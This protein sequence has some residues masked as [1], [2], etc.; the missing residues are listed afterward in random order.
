M[1]VREDSAVP[2][3][4]VVS[5]VAAYSAALASVVTALPGK[6]PAAM[7]TA[8]RLVSSFDVII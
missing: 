2:V 4:S 5:H 1:K 6:A 3:E 7:L 8:V